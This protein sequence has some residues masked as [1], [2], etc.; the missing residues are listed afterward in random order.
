MARV[1]LGNRDGD[2]PEARQQLSL[3]LANRVSL[4]VAGPKAPPAAEVF[5]E[6]VL[7]AKAA[8]G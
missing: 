8:R 3:R 5:L 1:F 6:M 2:T 7:W 4:F